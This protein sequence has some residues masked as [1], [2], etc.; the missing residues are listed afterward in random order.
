MR[1]AGCHAQD[2]T[3]REELNARL[4]AQNDLCSSAGELPAE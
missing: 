2:I 4:K 3:E 1:A